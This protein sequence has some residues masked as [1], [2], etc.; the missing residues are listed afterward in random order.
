MTP[1]R[2][3]SRSSAK[4]PSPSTIALR[5]AKRVTTAW[6]NPGGQFRPV[7]TAVPP[8]ASNVALARMGAFSSA[9]W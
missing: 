3:R 5:W 7:P 8:M 4:I 2:N 1:A 6:A 9:A